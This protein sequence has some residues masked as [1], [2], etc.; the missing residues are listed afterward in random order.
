MLIE[1]NYRLYEDLQIVCY[2]GM[3]KTIASYIAGPALI[4]WGKSIW[5]SFNPMLGLGIPTFG[6]AIIYK[7][8][9]DLNL[10]S[11]KDKYGFLYRGYKEKAYFWESVII[12]RK[13]CLIFI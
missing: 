1:G 13:I 12:Y 7:M 2:Q 8:R 3:H 6:F 5:T 4:F 10:K 9:F 11:V